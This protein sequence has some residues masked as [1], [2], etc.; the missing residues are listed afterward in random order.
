[1]D[2]YSKQEKNQ[3]LAYAN[4]SQTYQRAVSESRYRVTGEYW[5]HSS[6]EDK[7]TYLTGLA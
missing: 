3:V 4:Y 2:D 1:M 7:A 6:E 5:K